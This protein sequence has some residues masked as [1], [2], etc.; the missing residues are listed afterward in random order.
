M[1]VALLAP[2]F[3]PACDGVGDH[4][5][6]I[7]RALARNGDLVVVFTDTQAASGPVETSLVRAWDAS[8]V[9][10]TLCE[11]RKRRVSLLLIE[12]TPFNFGPRSIAPHAI[13]A[14]SRL[15]GIAVGLF[16]HEG[17]YG[18][19]SLHRTSPVK[20]A[21]LGARD[22]FIVAASHAT[23]TA[24]ESRRANLARAVPPL[25]SRLH[26]VPIGANV[27]PPADRVWRAPARRPYRLV[28]FGVVAPKRRLETL[29]EMLGAGMRRRLALELVVIGRIWDATYAE[30]C[31]ALATAL[32][33]A[34]HIRF[35]GSLEPDDVTRELMQGH[36]AVTALLEG[37]VS[38]SGSMLALLAHG[39]PVLAARTPH[40]EPAFDGVVAFT[41][42]EPAEMLDRAF[43]IMRSADGGAELGLRARARYER[44]FRW[45]NIAARA[46]W[47]AHRAPSARGPV[48]A[49]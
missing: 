4:A 31:L 3:P 40:D 34:A 30:R 16:L 18:S 38:A 10:L 47:L 1:T 36:L 41:S 7:A 48:H 46:Q 11:L 27:E 17:F 39:L 35:T 26:V 37:T 8:S 19:R 22:A 42:D 13:A 33:V 6:W 44:D 9:F 29:I 23:F 15:Q 45:D 5:A 24:S 25:A 32:G 21:L 14:L 20:A 49:T 28:T 43:E 2:R 12:Y